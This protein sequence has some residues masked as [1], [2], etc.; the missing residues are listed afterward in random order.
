MICQLLI[1]DGFAW[2]G[3]KRKSIVIQDVAHGSVR[4]W[5]NETTYEILSDLI[6][7]GSEIG[8]TRSFG[9]KSLR[10]KYHVIG[11]GIRKPQCIEQR[12]YVEKGCSDLWISYHIRAPKN[13]HRGST[14][15]AGKN[16]KWMITF[17]NIWFGGCFLGWANK[18]DTEET[19]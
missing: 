12:F 1:A 4:L 15:P 5:D 2:G 14:H 3:N 18:P 7:G 19:E 17:Y 9:D 10:L 8:Y 6:F 11:S 16:Y 13:H